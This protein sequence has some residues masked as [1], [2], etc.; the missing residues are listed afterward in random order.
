MRLLL[1]SLIV[2]P[3]FAQTAACVIKENTVGPIHAGMTIRAAKAALPGTVF[4]QTEEPGGGVGFFSVMRGAKR[5]MDLYPDQ[6]TGIK[7]T[8]KIELIRVYDPECSTE[9]GVHPGIPLIA[10]EGK[11]GHLKKLIVEQSEKREYAQF[12]TVP[13]WLEIQ[14]GSGQAGL[15]QPGEFCTTNYTVKAVVESLWVSHATTNDPL[16]GDEFCKAPPKI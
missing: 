7:E 3:V 9:E 16:A 13:S 14:T 4:K 2:A 6:E 10:V 11:F 1:L 5:V 15:Y 8:S 12:E